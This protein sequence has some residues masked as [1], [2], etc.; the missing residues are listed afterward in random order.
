MSRKRIV[1][2]WPRLAERAALWWSVPY[3][4]GAALAAVTGPAYGYALLGK[5]TGAAA[6]WSTAGLYAAAALLAYALPRRRAAPG[7]R[8]SPGR[9]S[10]SA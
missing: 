10:R 8:G 9:S 7:R 5:V 4:G 6:E 3:A 1:H 2:P